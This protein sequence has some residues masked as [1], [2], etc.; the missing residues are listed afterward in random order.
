MPPRDRNRRSVRLPSALYKSGSFFVT[1]CTRRRLPILGNIRDG[2]T[3]LS[4]LG[5]IVR[6]EW[7]RTAEIRPAVTLG[8]RIIMPDH[9][10]GVV[11]LNDITRSPALAPLGYTSGSL[12]SLINGFKS[13]CTRQHHTLTL[14]SEGS[15]WQ[16][17]F[18]EHRI[19]N[20]HELLAIEDYIR[21]NPLRW[22]LR[23][24][25]GK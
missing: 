2:S 19:R 1:I 12:S 11:H 6:A 22:E 4:P 5:K 17:G 15:M 18:Y 23:H 24:W 3:E 25:K 7:I 20:D 21:M 14:S 9:F 8:E 13:A 16:R 10:H